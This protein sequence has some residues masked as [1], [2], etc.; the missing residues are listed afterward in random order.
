MFSTLHRSKCQFA[1]LQ[2]L[3]P[4][5]DRRCKHKKLLKCRF[6]QKTPSLPTSWRIV[7]AST[8][9]MLLLLADYIVLSPFAV[10]STEQ[11][12][13]MQQIRQSYYSKVGACSPLFLLTAHHQR[14]SKGQWIYSINHSMATQCACAHKRN[15]SDMF[16][17]CR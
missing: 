6:S 17:Q 15:R 16:Q 4:I 2:L 12:A 14:T 8:L 9:H 13:S 3:R 5:W 7:A 11:I 10:S 1:P